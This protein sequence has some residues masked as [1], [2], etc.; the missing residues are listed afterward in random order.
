ML[1]AQLHH[2]SSLFYFYFIL[3]LKGICAEAIN[4]KPRNH[5]LFSY[6]S[7]KQ[8]CELKGMITK[9]ELTAADMKI[10][11]DFVSN[12]SIIC[13]KPPNYFRVRKVKTFIRN[14]N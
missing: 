4:I 11:Y 3:S 10:A 9:H 2:L 12:T 8:P 13:S 6:T 5:Q 7:Y 14:C 1:T